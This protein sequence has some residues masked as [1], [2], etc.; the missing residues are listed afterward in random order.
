VRS[1]ISKRNGAREPVLDSSCHDADVPELVRARAGGKEGDMGKEHSAREQV[2]SEAALL[3]RAI[4][5]YREMP[6]LALTLPQAVRLWGCDERACQ[7]VVSTL[8]ARGVLRRSRD[9]RFV[10]VE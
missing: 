4:A 5:E 3:Q 10:R 2:E 6:G 8:I 1:A 9:G 7:W